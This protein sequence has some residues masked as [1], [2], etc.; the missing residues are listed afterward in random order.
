MNLNDTTL[1]VGTVG[2]SYDAWANGIFYPHELPR[3]KWLS[4]YSQFFNF[5]KNISCEKLG[6]KAY[7]C[8][9]CHC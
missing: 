7:A 1:Y 2:F 4:Y 3:S 9:E 8:A 6:E 5:G